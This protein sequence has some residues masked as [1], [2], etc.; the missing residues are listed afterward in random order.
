MAQALYQQA[1]EVERQPRMARD[2]T[3]EGRLA[4]AQQLAIAQRDQL[5]RMRFARNHRHFAD[6]FARRHV[7]DEMI[8]ALVVGRIDAQTSGDDQKHGAVVFADAIKHRTARQTEPLRRIEQGVERLGP[9]VLHQ[10]KFAEP[11]PQFRRIKYM[12][13]TRGRQQG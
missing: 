9:D 2:Q 6:G 12:P 1:H 5:R 3:L 8:V 13:G 10:W 7:G 11:L 4:D